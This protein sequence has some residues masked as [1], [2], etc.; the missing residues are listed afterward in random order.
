MR[1]EVEECD[2]LHF[3]PTEEELESPVTA[4]HWRKVAS[5]PA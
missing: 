1:G 3:C 4:V 5:F 2:T